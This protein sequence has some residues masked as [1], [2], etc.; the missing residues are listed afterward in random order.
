MWLAIGKESEKIYAKGTHKVD[1]LRTLNEKY[2]YKRSKRYSV[3]V[4]KEQVLPEPLLLVKQ[5]H[6]RVIK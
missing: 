1:V 6:L 3:R 5:K 2:Q 4:T